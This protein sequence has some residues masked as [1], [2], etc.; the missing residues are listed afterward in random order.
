MNQAGF[1]KL[2]L[3]W[4]NAGDGT[5]QARGLG[6]D[7]LYWH[8]NGLAGIY[9]DRDTLKEAKQARKFYVERL[10]QPLREECCGGLDGILLFE[11]NGLEDVPR[12]FWAKSAL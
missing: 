1:E 7:N 11:V 12:V 9:Y 5:K 8:G 3:E 4:I 10:K 6:N 2:P